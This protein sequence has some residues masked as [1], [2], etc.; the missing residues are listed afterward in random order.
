VVPNLG[1]VRNLKG[2]VNTDF[3]ITSRYSDVFLI[4]FLFWDFR[5][6]DNKKG[7]TP[8]NKMTSGFYWHLIGLLYSINHI[9]FRVEEECFSQEK[10]ETGFLYMFYAF[11]ELWQPCE[12]L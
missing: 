7:W 9:K 11:V 10:N 3:F 4:S 1:Y 8:L 2:F 5:V 12:K 6:G